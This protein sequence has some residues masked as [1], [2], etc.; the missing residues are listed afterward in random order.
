MG[1][2]FL[3]L[4][5]QIEKR[6]SIKTNRDDVRLIEPCWLSRKPPDITAG[7]LHDWVLKLCHA[8]NVNVPHS[9]W[10]RVRLALA[11]TVGKPPQII[12]RDT[13][14]RRDLGFE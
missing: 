6:F 2:D 10:N 9:S 8:R 1:V 12:H 4:T 14:I 11:T 5:F 3:D 7:E 13:L